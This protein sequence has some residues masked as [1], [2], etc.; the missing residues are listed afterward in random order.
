[1]V[2]NPDESPVQRDRSQLEAVLAALESEL[3]GAKVI[4]AVEIGSYAKGEAIE[5]SDSDLRAYIR[6]TDTVYVLA[7]NEGDQPVGLTEFLDTQ[8]RV[9]T[10]GV[11]IGSLIRDINS[12][13]DGVV[14]NEVHIGFAD[15]EFADFMFSDLGRF[16]TQDHAMLLQ[17]IVLHDPEGWIQAQRAR[18]A[19][20][21]PP[22]GLVNM[23][24]AQVRRRA[25]ETLP[26][27]A[28]GSSNFRSADQWLL[29]A[30]RSIREAVALRSFVTEG[31]F[32]FHM[33]DVLAW[34]EQCDSVDRDLVS[35]LYRWK[36]DSATR[37]AVR[38]NYAEGKSD[39]VDIFAQLTPEVQDVVRNLTDDLQTG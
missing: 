28:E 10:E 30:V 27:Y 24:L 9:N 13:Q 16:P 8:S 26:W 3:P 38:A 35:K 33:N 11:Y 14:D 39:W 15:A 20:M 7:M 29:E 19:R 5:E 36:C 6:C 4:G 32:V 21:Q 1:M 17:S 31:A 37:A 2:Y 12:R 34:V 25:F 18:L 23:Y 22:A